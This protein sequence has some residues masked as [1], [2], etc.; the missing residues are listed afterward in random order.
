VFGRL[1]EASDALAMQPEPISIIVS[2]V[3]GSC[4]TEEYDMT[5]RIS[6][7]RFP[8]LGVDVIEG[9]KSGST[10][11]DVIARV[12]ANRAVGDNP[13]PRKTSKPSGPLYLEQ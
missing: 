10:R 3:F 2:A 12:L 4:S 6:S 13:S 8:H 11:D 1:W 7:P 9:L 5:I